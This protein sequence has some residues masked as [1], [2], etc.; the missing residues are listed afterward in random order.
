M[1][2]LYIIVKW[3]IYPLILAMGGYYKVTDN[4]EEIEDLKNRIE[5]LERYKPNMDESDKR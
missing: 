4:S 3:V 2:T 5:I 1:V